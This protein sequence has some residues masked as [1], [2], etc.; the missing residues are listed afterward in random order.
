[1][2][3]LE[4]FERAKLPQFSKPIEYELKSLKPFLWDKGLGY[5][6]IKDILNNA[7]KKYKVEFIDAYD[8]EDSEYTSVGLNGGELCTN[9][10]IQIGL[11][12]YVS[13]VMNCETRQYYD[14][15]LRLA[16]AVISHEL[17]H[18]EQIYK[19]K[20]TYVNVPDPYDGIKKYLSDHKELGAYATQAYIELINQLD[21]DEILQKLKYD[22]YN[23]SLYSEGVKWFYTHFEPHE[24]EY[25]AFFKKIY[26]LLHEDL[27]ESIITELRRQ[28]PIDKI[29]PFEQLKKYKDMDD[30]FISFT[31]IDKLGINP[32]TT[33]DT[34]VG[35]YCYPLKQAWHFYGLDRGSIHN[36][37]FASSEQF[38]WVFKSPIKNLSKA[39]LA[40]KMKVCKYTENALKG[41]LEPDQIERLINNAENFAKVESQ[42]GF[43][44]AI[45]RKLA[46]QLL[47]IKKNVSVDFI[48]DEQIIPVWSK[49]FL[50]LGWNGLQDD[51]DG[52]IHD[53]EKCQAVFFS[54]KSI[55]I[56]D[57]IIN[58]E[59]ITKEIL[60]N[61]E[62]AAIYA[63]ENGIRIKAAEPYMMQD[64]SM[65][66]NYA[67][68]V[69]KGRW[70]AA[71]LIIMKDP[72]Y[73]FQYAA[74][75]IK[76]RWEEAEP[77]I[78]KL[79][80]PAYRYAVEILG[81]RWKE[82]EPIIMKHPFSAY[83]YARNVIKGR[84]EEAEPYLM[85]DTK[86]AYYYACNILKKR[87]EEAEPY[88]KKDEHEWK[89]YQ[90]S[91]GIDK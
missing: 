57:K 31:A 74:E 91:F 8:T 58:K 24:K 30:V 78:M 87:W 83:N 64:P 9:G 84:W 11:T 52:I 81:H 21:K 37:P 56:I 38:I 32:K 46:K 69:I 36:L 45:T 4:L 17:E 88:I 14:D 75:V 43:I 19:T 5:I 59:N 10:L 77:Y 68:N 25:K 22:V 73:A 89:N 86:F 12:S 6:E 76:G 66:V 23:L 48:R 28:G 90:L 85:K 82:A 40:D 62:E 49:I 3:Y 35:I 70:K 18:R 67:K 53:N 20:Q 71:E 47:S 41:H 26:E 50:D 79:S 72:Y 61:P 63:L 29:S 33:Y 13:E 34:P 27:N 1:M 2:R 7:L 39:K 54:I 65:A 51:G 16:T 55:K 60:N 42:G 15:F 80:N 44:W